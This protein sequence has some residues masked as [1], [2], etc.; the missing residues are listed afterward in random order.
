MA[1]SLI[2]P[3]LNTFGLS[4]PLPS[5]AALAA[6]RERLPVTRH[7]TQFRDIFLNNDVVVW[8]SGTGSGKTT[9]I[10]QYVA[11]L[12]R[13]AK[14]RGQIVCTQPRRLAATR[15]AERAAQE[16][17]CKL[18]AQVGFQIRGEDQISDKTQLMYVDFPKII[19]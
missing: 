4:E 8:S 3:V 5:L 9:Q 2:N 18:G 19:G 14:I 11:F 13:Q 15:V 10:P 1:S 6:D 17:G 16:A 12:S 7:L